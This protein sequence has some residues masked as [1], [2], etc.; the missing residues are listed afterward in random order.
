MVRYRSIGIQIEAPEGALDALEEEDV[1]RPAASAPA[2][3]EGY[4]AAPARS[5]GGIES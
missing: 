4:L 3:T 5:P 1:A 2:A